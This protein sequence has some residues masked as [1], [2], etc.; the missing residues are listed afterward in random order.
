MQFCCTCLLP[1]ANRI[2]LRVPGEILVADGVNARVLKLNLNGDVTGVLDITKS[3]HDQDKPLNLVTCVGL[4][5]NHFVL[6]YDQDSKNAF[7]EWFHLSSFQTTLQ[8][9]KPCLFVWLILSFSNYL[10]KENCIFAFSLSSPIEE[11]GG[12][13]R[14]LADTM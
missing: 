11:H 4:C 12:D 1:I 14:R 13:Y 5:R 3:L 6:M 2:P 10:R 9:K 7:V 8:V